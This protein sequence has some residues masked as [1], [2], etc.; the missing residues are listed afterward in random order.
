MNRRSLIQAGILLAAASGARAMPQNSDPLTA[1]I[2]AILEG[3]DAID[4]HRTGTAGDRA[5]ADWLQRE[6]EAAGATARLDPFPF[7]RRVPGECWVEA[8]GRRADGVPLFDGALGDPAPLESTLAPL[9]AGTDIGVVAFGPSLAHAGAQT[10]FRARRAG[11]HRAIVAVA[12]GDQVRPGLAVINADDYVKPFGPPVLQVATGAGEWLFPA[13]AA[14]SAARFRVHAELEKTQAYN[15]S[16][17][18]T[19]RRSEL[20]PL[21]IMTPRSGWWRCTSERGGGIVV[22]LECIR[23]FVRNP[24]DRT[25]IFTANSGHELGHLGLDAFAETPDGQF[26]RTFAWLHLGANF[27]ARDTRIRLQASTQSWLDEGLARFREHAIDCE[28]TPV[29]TRPFGEAR[30]VFDAGGQYVSILAEN[31]LF[32]HPDDRWP[33]AV[34]VDRTRAATDVMVAIADRLARV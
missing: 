33:E 23:H 21:V 30:N 11:V 14:R 15:V 34:D 7:V 18:V 9:D 8:A 1:R 10:L 28:S 22:F 24:P 27:A 2:T 16:A 5:T 26:D 6:I 25:V 19:G 12:A 32:H 3:W 29:G 13:A 4:D 20:A 31:S 17:T